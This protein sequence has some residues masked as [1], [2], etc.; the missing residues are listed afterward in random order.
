MKQ[1]RPEDLIK[2]LEKLREGYS[3][4]NY[5]DFYIKVTEDRIEFYFYEDIHA[6]PV[7]FILYGWLKDFQGK[8]CCSCMTMFADWKIST[9]STK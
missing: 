7:A 5:P 8:D 3:K 4:E 1:I 2:C 6:L 9:E